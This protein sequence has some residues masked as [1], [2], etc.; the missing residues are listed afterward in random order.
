MFIMRYSIKYCLLLLNCLTIIQAY[1]Q[2]FNSYEHNRIGRICNNPNC[3][4]CDYLHLLAAHGIDARNYA[5]APAILYAV[6]HPQVVKPKKL[7]VKRLPFEST[8]ESEVA[9]LI[10]IV[11]PRNT[12]L[13][14]DP[15]CGDARLLIALCDKSDATGIGYEINP[16]ITKLARTKVKK[17]GLSDRIKI[18]NVDSTLVNMSNA[19]VIVCYLFPSVLQKLNFNNARIAASFQHKIPNSKRVGNWWVTKKEIW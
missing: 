16:D 19:S 18:W 11:K 9:N 3:A 7:V 1:G 12:D 14:V 10:N 5:S 2:D 17:A 15:G 13:I 4:M 8:P 6:H